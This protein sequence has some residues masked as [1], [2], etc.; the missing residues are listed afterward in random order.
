MSALW[1]GGA[2]HPV[3]R[4]EEAPLVHDGDGDVPLPLLGLAASGVD[5]GPGIRERKGALGSH[6]RA[7]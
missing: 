7:P 4:E 3:Q 6:A 5:D 2:V 1:S